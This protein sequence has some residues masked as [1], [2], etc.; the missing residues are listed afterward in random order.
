MGLAN[1]TKSLSGTGERVR[2]VTRGPHSKRSSNYERPSFT[3]PT[4]TR[5]PVPAPIVPD[6]VPPTR[7]VYFTLVKPLIDR[8]LAAMLVLLLLPVMAV[9][10]VAL[11]VR[12]GRPIFYRQHRVGKNGEPFELWKFRTMRPD[13]RAVRLPVEGDQ[14]VCH[15]RDDDP[16]HVPFGSFLRRTSLDELPQFLNVVAG[17]MSLVGPRPELVEIVERYQPWQHQR[18]LVKP[19]ITGLWQVSGRGNGLMHENVEVDIEYLRRLSLRTDLAIM[20]RT[21]QVFFTRSGS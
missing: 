18:H 19:G 15:K 5:E 2:L 1:R 20:L 16:R 17:H 13:R 21:P 12:L 3:P 7:S 4:V 14:R 8:A 6:V 9:I 10:A 11:M